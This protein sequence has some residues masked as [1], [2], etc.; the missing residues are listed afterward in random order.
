[1]AMKILDTN[2]ELSA[3]IV[4]NRGQDTLIQATNFEFSD[5]ENLNCFSISSILIRNVNLG[6]FP[7]DMYLY[8]DW[9]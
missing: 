2:E 7:E 8:E 6:R 3:T 9:V 1:M 5:L 4:R